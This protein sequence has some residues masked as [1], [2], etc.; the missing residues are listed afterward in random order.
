[1]SD[2]KTAPHK[3][4]P[5]PPEPPTPRRLTV[6]GDADDVPREVPVVRYDV[7][8]DMP[9]KVAREGVA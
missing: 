7:P 5:Q 8:P 4:Q 6:E 2:E 1:M 3:A 9:C